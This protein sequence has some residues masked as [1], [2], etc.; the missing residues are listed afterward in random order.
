MSGASMDY[1]CKNCGQENLPGF[2][3]GRGRGWICR[4]CWLIRVESERVCSQNCRARKH[5]AEGTFTGAEWVTLCEQYGNKC[6]GCGKDSD[7][8]YDLV[9]D[10]ITPLSLGGTNWIDNI[11]PLCRSCDAKKRTR[12]VD[13]RPRK[14]RPFIAPTA[15]DLAD[16]WL[17]QQAER[18]L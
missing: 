2:M 14:P 4:R 10:H 9:I 7:R 8:S 18:G 15:D 11:Q 5:G 6:V 1:Q 3:R 13:H 12:R 16:F 17:I